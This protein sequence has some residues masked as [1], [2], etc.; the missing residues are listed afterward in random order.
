MRAACEEA[1]F[2]MVY[3]VTI[4]PVPDYDAW[5]ADV[6]ASG[7]VLGRLGVTRHWLFRATDDHKEVMNVFEL[8]SVEHAKRMLRD[9][10]LDIPA[11]LDR[12]GLEI[13][14]TFFLGEPTEFKEYPAAS[15]A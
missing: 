5:V 14:P 10:D 1:R 3:L 4:L 8:P 6:S 9:P 11:W 2:P 13:Y 12:A 15:E 7:E